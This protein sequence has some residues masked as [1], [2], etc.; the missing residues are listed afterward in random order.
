MDNEFSWFTQYISN[1][2][3][4]WKKLESVLNRCVSV[5]IIIE[6]PFLNLICFARNESANRDIK[7]SAKYCDFIYI[8]NIIGGILVLSN[9]LKK[10]GI[11]ISITGSNI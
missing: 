9:S 8:E 4:D 6:T 3:L 10:K 11:I 1:F 7:K 2:P 5:I